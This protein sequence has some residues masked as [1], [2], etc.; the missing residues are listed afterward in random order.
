MCASLVRCLRADSLVLRWTLQQETFFELR[1]V[2]SMPWDHLYFEVMEL[3]TALHWTKA[4]ANATH[5]HAHASLRALLPPSPCPLSALSPPL[6]IL[7]PSSRAAFNVRL[8]CFL[9]AW[10]TSTWPPLLD[11]GLKGLLEEVNRDVFRWKQ[12]D[13]SFNGRDHEEWSE[14]CFLEPVFATSCAQVRAARMAEGPEY[15]K[16]RE[17]MGE[18]RWAEVELLAKTCIDKQARS[19]VRDLGWA[20]GGVGSDDARHTGGGHYAIPATFGPEVCAALPFAV[21]GCSV[22]AP[23]PACRQQTNDLRIGSREAR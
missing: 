17:V 22:S 3:L 6:F 10:D 19:I 12:S 23:S 4:S 1:P 14:L 7:P 20:G 9:A 16:N 5:A 2:C 13:V 8:A 15:D 18:Q 11:F 21:H